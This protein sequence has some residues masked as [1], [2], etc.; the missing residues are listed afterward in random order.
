MGVFAHRQRQVTGNLLFLGCLIIGTSVPL[1]IVLMCLVMMCH[2]IQS[3]PKVLEQQVQFL[4]FC[5]T[6][7]TFKQ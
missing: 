3:P 1:L 2:V 6:L 5:N 4:C 7:N